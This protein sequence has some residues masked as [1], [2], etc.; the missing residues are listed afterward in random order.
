M[1]SQLGTTF[2][3]IETA[4]NMQGLDRRDA[5]KILDF[6]RK[7]KIKRICSLTRFITAWRLNPLRQQIELSEY[8]RAKEQ[9]L[10]SEKI[11]KQDA[12]HQV[13]ANFERIFGKIEIFL[14]VPKLM[15]DKDLEQRRQ[16][17]CKQLAKK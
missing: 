13:I 14:P 3:D 2:E 17:I 4:C 9:A 12:G 8:V 1:F 6:C 5:A 16:L 11:R 10:K 7:K 15:S